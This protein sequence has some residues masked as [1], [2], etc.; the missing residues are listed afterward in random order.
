MWAFIRATSE[1]M[2]KTADSRFSSL[3]S[4]RSSF[5]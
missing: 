3:F 5:S 2:D 4:M 1:A